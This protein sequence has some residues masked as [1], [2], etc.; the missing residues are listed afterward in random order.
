MF[1]RIHRF[2][3]TH[4]ERPIIFLLRRLSPNGQPIESYGTSPGLSGT[5]D[6]LLLD[7]HH[8]SRCSYSRHPH[9]FPDGLGAAPIAGL[10]I[11]KKKKNS[12][13]NRYRRVLGRTLP[14]LA[15]SKRDHGQETKNHTTSVA[16]EKP[17][18]P[19]HVL[20]SF[21]PPGEAGIR[22]HDTL[23]GVAKAICTPRRRGTPTT[24]PLRR[25][26]RWC[27]RTRCGEQT[28]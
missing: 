1:Q 18:T 14:L 9:T 5:N 17:L 28:G 6:S 12:A 11:K 2:R 7:N 10:D 15:P 8:S 23:T 22:L 4:W 13:Q 27:A 21:H 26:G 25:Q 20:P 16:T 24:P 3:R 19:R